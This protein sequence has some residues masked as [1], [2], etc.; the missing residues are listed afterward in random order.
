MT[1]HLDSA[2]EKL[3]GRTPSKEERE[4]LLRTKEA[5][6]LGDRDSLW[7]ILIA[8]GHY[9]KL[10]EEIPAKAEQ[11]AQAAREAANE[12]IAR[13]HAHADRVRAATHAKLI[14]ELNATLRRN[15][16]ARDKLNTTRI[17]LATLAA[18]LVY[19]AAVIAVTTLLAG[20]EGV[21]EM[22]SGTGLQ[23]LVSLAYNIPAGALIIAAGVGVL[24]AFPILR[25]TQRFW[26]LFGG[27][28]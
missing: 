9:E 14:R 28:I 5:L 21:L 19:T 3:L 2:F 6:G 8:L 17:A 22:A 15:L 11:A 10:Y 23:L 4:R 26:G 20:A 27:R 24:A 12:E 7:L 25:A 1:Q 13:V 18:L 16:S